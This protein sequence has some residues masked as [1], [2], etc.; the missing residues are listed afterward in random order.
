MQK[1]R[2]YKKISDE[3]L[4]KVLNERKSKKDRINLNDIGIRLGLILLFPYIVWLSKYNED[5]VKTVH[6][7]AIHFNY[8]GIMHMFHNLFSYANT[9]IHEAGHGICDM[10]PC[11]QF[12]TVLSGILFQLALPI[13][14]IF[15][16]YK[17]KNQILTGLGFI[18]LA[19]NLVYV[20]GYMLNSHTPNL[21]PPFPKGGT[22]H[23]FRYIF[24]Q[25]G[26]LEY[27]WL[28]SG[29]VRTTAIII[30]VSAYLYLLFIA[31]IQNH[32]E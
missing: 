10:L 29:F 22:I 16:N 25:L 30:M 26:V 7:K 24:S 31:F 23:D 1:R 13:I 14:F 18:W 27:D 2:K 28:I 4:L 5:Y 6:N 15:Y 20:A 9:L 21:Y 19:Q 8:D 12:I 17:R 32:E 11:S 3:D